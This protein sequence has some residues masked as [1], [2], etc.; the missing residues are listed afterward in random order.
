MS[1]NPESNLDNY[2]PVRVKVISDGADPTPYHFGLV[3][4][5]MWGPE[6]RYAFN[7]IAHMIGTSPETLSA[8]ELVSF[9]FDVSVLAH[10]EARDRGLAVEVP[11]P[12]E[13]AGDEEAVVAGPWTRR[14]GEPE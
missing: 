10:R 3:D 9:A 2:R 5:E 14:E 13:P 12:P 8:Q 7:L 4:G 1:K 11:F 6:A